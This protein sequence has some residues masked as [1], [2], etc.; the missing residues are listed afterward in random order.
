MIFKSKPRRIVFIVFVLILLPIIGLFAFNYDIRHMKNKGETAISR[1]ETIPVQ[2]AEARLTKLQETLELTGEI[3]SAAVVD[4]SFKVGGERIQKIYVETGDYVT[5]GTLIA[6]LED[7]TIRSQIEEATAGL[8]AAEAALTQSEVNAALLEKNRLRV[9]N[10]YKEN[11]VSQQEL[12]QINA[13]CDAALEAKKLA[14]AQVERAKAALNQLQILYQEHKL[15]APISGFVATRYVEE[16]SRIGAAQPVIRIS[17][18]DTLKIVCSVPE[19]DFPYL[20]KGMKAEITVDAFPG[21]VFEGFLSIISPTID[22]AIRTVEI[23]IHIP[24]EKHELRSGM[25]ARVKLY[26]GEREALV[27]PAESLCKMAGTGSYYVYTVKDNKA[28]LKNVKTGITQNSFIEIIE[29]LTEKELVVTR[30]QNRLY[31][32]AQVSVEERGVTD[33]EAS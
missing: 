20:K 10:L 26:L 5:K 27:V 2:V 28:V 32:G 1:E 13:Q 29:G 17:Q 16:G 31:D 25:F 8:A 19:K 7:A 23:K 14:S 33:S 18:E 3:K 22:P 21:K 9:E 24:N 11:V 30:G 15:Y 4:V 6:V 12:D